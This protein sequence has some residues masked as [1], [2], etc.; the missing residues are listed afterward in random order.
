MQITIKYKM[1]QAIF[2]GPAIKS[3]N[4]NN[5]ALTIKFLKNNLLAF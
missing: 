3:N 5:M 2:Q 1:H 4:D